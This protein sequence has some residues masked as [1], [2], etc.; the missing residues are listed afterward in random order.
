MNIDM[1]M[2]QEFIARKD[3]VLNLEIRLFLTVLIVEVIFVLF[4]IYGD[5][6]IKG[7]KQLSVLALSVYLVFIFELIAINGKMGLISIYLCQMESYLQSLGYKGVI[8]ESVALD[9]IIYIPGNAFTLPVFIIILM[10]LS[11][12]V[13]AFVFTCNSL[14][15]SKT[16]TISITIFFVFFIS[17]LVVKALTVD[18]FRGMPQLFT[19]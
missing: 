10:L 8:W 12:A 5:Y 17:F 14:E 6:R 18:F 7:K 9:K 3:Q 13:Y 1:P 19:R 4:Y 15:L 2:I 11:Q 16:K